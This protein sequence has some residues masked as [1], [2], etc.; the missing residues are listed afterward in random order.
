MSFWRNI[1]LGTHINKA[2]IPRTT[3]KD[4]LDY[5]NR[6]E[7]QNQRSLTQIFRPKTYE[8]ITLK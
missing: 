5:S 7:L 6:K 1:N 2:K 4:I 8:N 3:G